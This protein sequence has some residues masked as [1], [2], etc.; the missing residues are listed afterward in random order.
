MLLIYETFFKN[1]FFIAEKYLLENLW[2]CNFTSKSYIKEKL[3]KKYDHFLRNSKKTYRKVFFCKVL[4]NSIALLSCKSGVKQELGHSTWQMPPNKCTVQ[5]AYLF[6]K[7][8]SERTDKRTNRLTDER[9]DGRSDFIMPQI[10]FGSIK[11]NLPS[12]FS[13]THSNF[14][15]RS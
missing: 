11:T 1:K 3:A 5:M 9:T 2:K 8:K 12:I 4:K 13:K 7:T 6:K 14:A 15:C 10:L